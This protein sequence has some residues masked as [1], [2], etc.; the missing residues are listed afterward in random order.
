MGAISGGVSMK[1]RFRV[2]IGL[3]ADKLSRFL[4]QTRGEYLTSLLQRYG[5]L[6][7]VTGEVKLN[8]PKNIYVGR[9]SYVNGGMLFASNNA[10]IRIGSNCMI[11]YNVHLRTDMHL[12]SDTNVPMCQ[13]G[14]SERDI[15]IGD[16][17][18]IGYG[19]Q[20]LAGV[21]VGSGSI[22]GAG[23]V[24]TKDVPPYVIVGGVP[25]KII[26]QRKASR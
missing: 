20:I 26:H 19:A 1:E 7:R 6:G 13:Q 10:K 16:D 4:I 3:L 17:V 11:S 24:V 9:G 14:H 23:A 18:W 2:M 21:S 5:S 12:H 22:V 25:A 15:I 8:N